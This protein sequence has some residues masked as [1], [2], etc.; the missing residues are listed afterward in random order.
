MATT[1]TRLP[2]GPAWDGWESYNAFATSV[3]SGLR[4]VRSKASEQ[5]LAKVRAS[6][7]TRRLVIPQKEI[8]WRARLG[9][10]YEQVSN[11][12]PD[13]TVVHDEERPYKQEGMKPIPNWQGEGRANPRGIPSLYLATTRDTALAEVRPWLGATISVA[14]LQV[15]RC[16]HVIDCAKHH[17]RDSIVSIDSLV[18]V[19]RDHT[20]TEE[21]G[22]WFAIDR[23]FATPV[24]KEDEARDYI[25]TQIIAELFKSEGYDGIV[26]K[27]LLSDDGL[28]I[29]LFNLDDANVIHG[30]LFKTDS[31]NFGFKETGT[32]TS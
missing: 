11:T 3:K 9:C 20:K 7:A 2:F 30:A 22:I 15:E 16:L 8:F 13:I 31:I 29:A 10:E 19:F 28:N 6:C 12:H 17:S 25:P 27:S 32:D 24:S 14:Q 1:E 18:R 4:Y 26:Y 5:F 21:D 23:A